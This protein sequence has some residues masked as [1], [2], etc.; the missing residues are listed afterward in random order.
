MQWD[1]FHFHVI[2]IS[3]ECNENRLI[4]LVIIISKGTI[5]KLQPICNNIIYTQNKI[6]RRMSKRQT[7]MYVVH[8][9]LGATST[10]RGC[11]PATFISLKL[12]YNLQQNV[13]FKF[14]S[15][16]RSNQGMSSCY[17]IRPTYKRMA[18]ICLFQYFLG[19]FNRKNSSHEN[20]KK[21]TGQDLAKRQWFSEQCFSST[22]CPRVLNLW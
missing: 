20:I 15:I 5:C 1:R 13:A 8:P 7:R 17:N 9:I 21:L 4:S 10:K 12:G 6:F 3:N 22:K 16:P 11:M 18:Y 2:I 14:S 19:T